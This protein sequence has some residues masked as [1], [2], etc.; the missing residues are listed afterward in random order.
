LDV[1]KPEDVLLHRRILDECANNPNKRPIFHV[2]FLRV[3]TAPSCLEF[4]FSL[5]TESAP[6]QTKRRYLFCLYM[7][8]AFTAP[9][10]QKTNHRAPPRVKTVIVG[11]LLPPLWGTR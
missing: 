8:S 3:S 10:I 7:N 6:T 11:A 2:R 5:K 4:V 1:E 9:W